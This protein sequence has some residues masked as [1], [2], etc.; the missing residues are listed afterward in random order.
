M[1]V[2]PMLP[3]NRGVSPLQ[4]ELNKTGTRTQQFYAGNIYCIQGPLFEDE[5]VVGKVRLLLSV[6]VNVIKTRL[7]VSAAILG[8]QGDKI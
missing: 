5:V 3:P 4:M 7:V 8:P 2:D 6:S 1:S